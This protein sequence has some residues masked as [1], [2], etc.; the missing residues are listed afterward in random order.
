MKFINFSSPPLKLS[1]YL[2]NE[3]AKA[4]EFRG[5]EIEI[6]L[7]RRC[8]ISRPPILFSPKPRMG[9]NQRPRRIHDKCVH[10]PA[11]GLISIPPRTLR[12]IIRELMLTLDFAN[13]LPVG[14]LQDQVNFQPQTL[15]R[16]V[17]EA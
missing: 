13:S 15:L 8:P 2:L 16:F 1:S 9:R 11:K 4:T 12:E 14:C 3:E 5:L 7:K 17:H 6:Y 10:Q